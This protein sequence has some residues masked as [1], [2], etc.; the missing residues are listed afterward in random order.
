MDVL[1]TAYFAAGG[2]V[3]DLGKIDGINQWK[4]I[5]EGNNNG[6]RKSLVYLLADDSTAIRVE[7][8]KLITSEFQKQ[9]R[10]WCG[11]DNL[12]TRPVMYNRV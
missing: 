11:K 7:N 3:K 9:T 6:D 10:Y 2:D 12:H 8:Y 5:V 1:P 4:S